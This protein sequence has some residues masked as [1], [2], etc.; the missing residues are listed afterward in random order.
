MLKSMNLQVFENSGAPW[1]CG[2]IRLLTA[3]RV[4]RS[5][6]VESKKKKKVRSNSTIVPDVCIQ[7][8]TLTQ[9]SGV[10]IYLN[11]FESLYN[12]CLL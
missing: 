9:N 12:N 2:H 11:V 1:S 5:N 8:S 3:P 7:P 6:P 4:G 10:L